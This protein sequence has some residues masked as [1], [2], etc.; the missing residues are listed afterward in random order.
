MHLRIFAVTMPLSAILNI[1]S[2]TSFRIGWY[3]N[4]PTTKDYLEVFMQLLPNSADDK[5]AERLLDA[6]M[7]MCSANMLEYPQALESPSSL[8]LAAFKLLMND[9]GL[10]T[11]DALCASDWMGRIHFV[12]DASLAGVSYPLC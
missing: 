2:L 6:A 4:G 10:E 12:L 7:E 1:L 11:K 8:A 3:L 9:F 5:T